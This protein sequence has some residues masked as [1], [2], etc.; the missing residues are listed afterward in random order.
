MIKI[1]FSLNRTQ[2]Q[3]LPKITSSRNTKI[4]SKSQ[5]TH[6]IKDNRN[7][8]NM[9]NIDNPGITSPKNSTRGNGI[10]KEFGSSNENCYDLI[11]DNGTK[12]I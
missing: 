9:D 6:H 5:Y 8:S 2:N 4:N 7:I 10:K 12:K 1:F 11:N 3:P